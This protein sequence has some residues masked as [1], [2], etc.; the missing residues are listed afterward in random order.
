MQTTTKFVA[1]LP[2][3][4]GLV[5]CAP[6]AE[7]EEEAV[8]LFE[9]RRETC[10]LRCELLFEP[11]CGAAEVPFTDENE[12][13]EQCMSEDATNWGLQED[14]TDACAEEYS[15]LHTCMAG[16]TCEEQFII[17]N[18]PAFASQTPCAGELT[19]MLECNEDNSE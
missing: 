2:L 13:T 6:E 8:E 14:G 18:D 12:C 10:E 5:A 11:E 4:F 3:L 1:I 7:E 19:A 9:R 16:A 15:T 17:I